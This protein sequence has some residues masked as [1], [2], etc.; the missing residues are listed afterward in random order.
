ML[1]QNGKKKKRSIFARV[2]IAILLLLGLF[3]ALTVLNFVI[4]MYEIIQCAGQMK[5]LAQQL[6][7]YADEHD[8][9]YPPTLAHVVKATSL[10]DYM[11]VCPADESPG[12]DG[13]Y[14]FR[15]ADLPTDIPEASAHRLI[16]IYEK[17]ANHIAYGYAGAFELGLDILTFNV[18]NPA[19]RNAVSADGTA[20]GGTDEGF[21]E[22]V[23]IDNLERK[24]LGLPEKPLEIALP[25]DPEP[26]D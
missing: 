17:D 18:F 13:S 21:K 19:F 16:L 4:P 1:L 24:R 11:L 25:A 3:I 6:Q 7:L 26:P 2:V 22:V 15:G 10:S 5:S 23:R 9:Q 20:C 8:G 12:E 14:V